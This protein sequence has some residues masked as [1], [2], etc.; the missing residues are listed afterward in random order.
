MIRSYN[1]L[2]GSKQVNPD[3]VLV[4]IKSL[5]WPATE[6]KK[7]SGC[8]CNLRNTPKMTQGENG[9]RRN[10]PRDKMA[11][12]KKCIMANMAREKTD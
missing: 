9:P 6:A 12:G 10:R 1:Y 5:L 3:Q 11:H 4:L 2:Q 8:Y 7:L